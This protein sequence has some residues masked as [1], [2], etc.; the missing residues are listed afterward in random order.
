MTEKNS[1]HTLTAALC[2]YQRAPLLQEALESLVTQELADPSRVEVLVVDN[3][4]TDDTIEI[5]RSFADRF[6]CALRV[7]TEP[8]KGLSFAR[9]TA[10]RQAQGNIVAFLDDDA[11]A[12]PTW[13]AGHLEAY[14]NDA[15]VCAVMGRILP[16]WEADRPKWLDVALDSYLTIADYGEE[17]F[18]LSFPPQAPVGANMSFLKSALEEVGY[19]DPRFGV[20]GPKA[21]PYEENELAHRLTRH[22]M[23]MVYWPRAAVWHGVPAARATVKWLARR[24]YAQGRAELIFD[25]DHKP[26]LRIIKKAL[27]QGTIRGPV[28]AAGALVD[29]LMGKQARAVRRASVCCHTLGYL[30]ELVVC[31]ARPSKI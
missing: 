27:A 26:K 20:G 11:V 12:S 18:V 28:L 4:S 5:S 10:I 23:K 24:I 8:R 7:V 6:S 30:R 31:M 1:L 9:N 3:G 14:D 25:M 29:C 22:G 17:P 21:I 15:E 13:A 16:R 19:F 2:T